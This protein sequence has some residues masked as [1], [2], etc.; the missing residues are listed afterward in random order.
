MTNSPN[1][2][3]RTIY[4]PYEGNGYEATFQRFSA[5]NYCKYVN[6]PAEIF[7]LK[8]RY[9]YI[10]IGI[11]YLHWVILNDQFT[12]TRWYASRS[13]YHGAIILPLWHI[14]ACKGIVGEKMHFCFLKSF[15]NVLMIQ[16]D[17]AKNCIRI[18]NF[19]IA[20]RMFVAVLLR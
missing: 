8:L 16:L 20:K 11:M 14:Q 9:I 10:K 19:Y 15:C 3:S 18:F 17:S 1:V 2:D 12:P 13:T 5:C 6:C 7:G 4:I